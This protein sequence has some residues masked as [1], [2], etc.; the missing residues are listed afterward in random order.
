MNEK[1]LLITIFLLALSVWIT[2][3]LPFIL[4][5]NTERLPG[6]VEYLGRVLPAAMMGLL[7]VYCFKDYSFGD[8][9]SVGPALLSAAA[10]AALHLWKGNTVLSIAAGTALYMILIRC[11]G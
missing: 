11:I 5:R 1:Q 8:I 4:F 7:V 10:V 6:I 9:A 2:R 3:F